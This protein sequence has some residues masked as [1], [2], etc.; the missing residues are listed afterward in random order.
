MNTENQMVITDDM[1]KAIS[2]IQH[3]KENVYLTGKAGTGKTTLLKYIIENIDKSFVV[4]A[5]TGIAAI[6][7][8]GCTLHSLFALPFSVYKPAFANGLTLHRLPQYMASKQK[9]EVIRG[10]DV[11][12]IDEI[13]MV[14]ADLLDA[15][16]DALCYYRKTRKLFGGVQLLMVGDIHQ[17]S[18]VVKGDEWNIVRDV[19]DSPFFF[20]SEALKLSKFKTVELKHIFRQS[21]ER[22]IKILNEI[23]DGNMSQESQRILLEKTD[24]EYN[25]KNNAI[26]IVSHNSIADETNYKKLNEIDAEECV[27]SAS[28]SGK[29]PSSSIPC[30]MDLKLKVGAQIMVTV[31]SNSEGLYNGMLGTVVAIDKK[32]DII[33]IESTEGSTYKIPKFKWSNNEYKIN[34]DTGVVESVEVGTCTQFPLKLAW[35]ITIHKSQGL[36]FDEV[37]ID[38]NKSFAH[39]Q[40]YVALSRCRTLDGIH[41]LSPVSRR[42]AICDS[43][44]KEVYNDQR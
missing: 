6:N 34:E 30:D 26:R 37:I 13:S 25:P 4:T 7:A 39:G 41:L 17:L 1:E 14:R 32:L 16:N 40:L 12:I 31:N 20:Q 33:T 15:V 3:T 36:T 19:Y 44:I 9:Q 38:A 28:V 24:T 35:A 27:F 29:F 23:R 2:L 5:P 18:P 10:I 42:Q 43:R 11:L 8:G 22:F 21:E